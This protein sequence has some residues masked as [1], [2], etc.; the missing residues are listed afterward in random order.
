M[1]RGVGALPDQGSARQSARKATPTDAPSSQK[2]NF[3]RAIR[4]TFFGQASFGTVPS[5]VLA[6]PVLPG[7]WGG[8]D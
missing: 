5:N 4:N 3:I 7:G 8:I 2:F 6:R 1:V